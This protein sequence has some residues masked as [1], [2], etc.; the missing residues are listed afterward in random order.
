M[1]MWSSTL[2]HEVNA[3]YVFNNKHYNS[4]ISQFDHISMKKMYKICLQNKIDIKGYRV[5]SPVLKFAPDVEAGMIVLGLCH[6]RF[7]KRKMTKSTFFHNSK[8]LLL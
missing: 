6:P 8:S 2:L 4:F 7:Y 1:V 3:E 5:T